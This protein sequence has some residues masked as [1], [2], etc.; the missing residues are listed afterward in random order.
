M[1]EDEPAHA[2]PHTVHLSDPRL[3][4]EWGATLRRHSRRGLCNGFAF[5][6]SGIEYVGSPLG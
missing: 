5:G 4:P 2:A 1:T 3:E 6:R